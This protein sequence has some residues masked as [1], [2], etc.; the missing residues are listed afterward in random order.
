MILGLD[1]GT[2]LGWALTRLDDDHHH[3]VL[4]GYGVLDLPTKDGPLTNL[5]R[6][7]GLFRAFE[8]SSAAAMLTADEVTGIYVE[9]VPFTKYAK[10]SASYWRVRTLAEIAAAEFGLYPFTIVNVSTLKQW[11][12]G[13]GNADKA[14]MCRA[15]R[16]RFDVPLYARKGDV[17]KGS[18]AHEDQADAIL[19]AAWAH[20]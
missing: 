12:T 2:S 13:K 6:V 18:K 15:A 8:P 7:R 11:A 4:H 19:V 9:D 1:V 5:D 20:S 14:A 16:E 17:E 3:T 10:A